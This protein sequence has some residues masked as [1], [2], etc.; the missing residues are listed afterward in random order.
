MSIAANLHVVQERIAR[1][2]ARAH[3]TPD[4]LTLIAVTK[5]VE[6]ARI[7]EVLVAG[8][9]HVGENKV[10]DAAPKITELSALPATWHMIGHLQSNKVKKAVELFQTIH[11]VDSLRLAQE[12]QARA[13]QQHKTIE[14]L[15]EVNVSQE[16]SKFGLPPAEVLTV[17]PA[18]AA[19]EGIMLTGLMT[20]APF[21]SNP[22][23]TR[24]YFRQ[25]RELLQQLQDQG[26]SQMTQL[27]MGM[28]NDFEVAIEEGATLVRIGTAIFG[29]R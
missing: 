5:T 1:A 23:E 28:T 29:Q 27:S 16:A 4:N 3:R 17:A 8:V 22:E 15:L 20:M 26:L 19:L 24:P 13:Q 14:I 25:L 11:A 9:Q 6:V 10:Q 2:L 18:V 7:Q 12:I 21:V